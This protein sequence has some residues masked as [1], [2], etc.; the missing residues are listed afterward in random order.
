M[1]GE[2]LRFLLLIN[3]GIWQIR[4]SLCAALIEE[5]ASERCSLIHRF[6][7][8]LLTIYDIISSIP[9]RQGVGFPSASF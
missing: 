8:H 5:L 1:S 6:D 2:W 4:Q 3:V 7:W 9:I